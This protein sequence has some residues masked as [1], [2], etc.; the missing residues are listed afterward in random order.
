MVY[1]ILD[2]DAQESAFDLY[3]ALTSYGLNVQ[4]IVPSGKDA[5]EMG[6][7]NIWHDIMVSRKMD[8]KELVTQR[9]YAT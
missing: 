2:T 7:D 8:F 3:N 4:N 1:I 5:N 9:L 6:F